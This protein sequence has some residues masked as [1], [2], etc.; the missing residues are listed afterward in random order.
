MYLFWIKKQSHWP[1]S[2][3]YW[4]YGWHICFYLF[5]TFGISKWQRRRSTL[6][7]FWKLLNFLL[8]YLHWHERCWFKCSF[9]CSW[10]R[11][12]A[13]KVNLNYNRVQSA[14]FNAPIFYVPTG[15]WLT[16]SLN[17]WSRLRLSTTTWTTS[18]SARQ[19]D[20]SNKSSLGSTPD[21]TKKDSR[22]LVFKRNIFPVFFC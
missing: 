4:S 21:S 2:I 10:A 20:N 12:F 8:T 13:Q 16:W 11:N 15:Q 5:R 18:L 3:K 1:Y 9:L 19:N 6:L 22:E 7:Y 14:L 17:G